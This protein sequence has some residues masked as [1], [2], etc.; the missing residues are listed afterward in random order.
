VLIRLLPYVGDAAG[1]KAKPMADAISGGAL[2]GALAWTAL[3]AAACLVL[4]GPA[5]VLAPLCASAL[6]LAWMARLFRRRLQASPAIVWARRSRCASSPATWASR[7]RRHEALAGAPRRAGSRPR[8]VLW[9]VRPR[10]GC[11]A[12]DQA[13]AAL[14]PCLPQG[15]GARCSPLR[16]AGNWP[17][18]CSSCAPTWPAGRRPAGGFDFGCWEGQRW[19][20][21]A[22]EEYARWTADF[23]HY[24]F[25][26]ARAWRN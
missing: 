12:T 13:A 5:F 20:A 19:S 3:A 18:P 14:A 6:A 10:R 8:A 26:G 24:R 17:A 22:Q 21:I 1:S 16:A 23:A 4:Q 15:L 9:R 2:A 25:G 7:W 11:H